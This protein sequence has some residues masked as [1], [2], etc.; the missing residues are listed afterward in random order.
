[1]QSKFLEKS[2]NL[3][4]GSNRI[5]WDLDLGVA[6]GCAKDG[7]GDHHGSGGGDERSPGAIQRHGRVASVGSTRFGLVVL[8]AIATV[9]TA[10]GSTCIEDVVAVSI[11]DPTSKLERYATSL[12]HT[13]EV[14]KCTQIVLLRCANNS[15]IAAWVVSA[16]GLA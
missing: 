3:V 16:I 4:P 6:V 14:A 5:A 9:I 8:E 11:A 7:K 13:S 12:S 15:I 10:F 1:M 2:G